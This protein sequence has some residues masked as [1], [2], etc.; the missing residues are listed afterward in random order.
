MV[1]LVSFTG[2][3]TVTN[4][5][6]DAA[7]FSCTHATMVQ[8]YIVYLWK[9]TGRLMVFY[10][11]D[12]G[13]YLSKQKNS[14]LYNGRSQTEFLPC[15]CLLWLLGT[16]LKKST[17]SKPI[18]LFL[19]RGQILKLSYPTA[20]KDHYVVL[21]YFFLSK[22]T[23]IRQGHCPLPVGD[24]YMCYAVIFLLVEE[25]NEVFCS[26]N[27]RRSQTKQRW[28]RQVKK[29]D[30]THHWL[31]D[32]LGRW[33]ILSRYIDQKAITCLSWYLLTTSTHNNV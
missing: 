9:D 29:A 5:E 23:L 1:R 4:N 32:S 10:M 30:L 14:L 15:K 28:E 33:K 26:H 12:T 18:I 17:H 2:S 3:F 7:F 13:I 11:S 27:F 21:F 22:T 25:S 19:R 8:V 6:N 16:P 24:S 31:Y 20:L